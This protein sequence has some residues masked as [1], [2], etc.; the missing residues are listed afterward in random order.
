MKKRERF[1][2]IDRA[3]MDAISPC[4]HYMR[5]RLPSVHEDGSES[6]ACMQCDRD[7]AQDELVAACARLARLNR[8]DMAFAK[9]LPRFDLDERSGAICEFSEGRFVSRAAML[10]LF[11]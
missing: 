5:F 10:A 7:K 4:G 8:F 2:P 1:I 9:T 11:K 3:D 6:M